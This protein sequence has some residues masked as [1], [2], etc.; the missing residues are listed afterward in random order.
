[1]RDAFGGTFL[2]YLVITFVVIFVT[3]LAVTMKYIQA[4]RVKN[5]IINYIEQYE[6]Y[7]ENVFD[8]LEGKDG[9]KGYLDKVG[10]NE[11][12]FLAT[13]DNGINSRTFEIKK[14]NQEYC[15][16]KYGY[17]VTIK[18]CSNKDNDGNCQKG[19]I[20]YYKVTTCMSLDFTNIL[21]FTEPIKINIS[22]ETRRVTLQ[23]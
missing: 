19:S 16:T 2:M 20:A 1:M 6:G 15:S 22:G 13:S 12:N 11:N 3:F 17:C 4:Y 7:N 9:Q 10:Y 14:E 8:H 18:Y 23:Y 5:E 21:S